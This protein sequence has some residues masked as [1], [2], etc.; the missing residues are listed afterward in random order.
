MANI[1]KDFIKLTRAA[2]NRYVLSEGGN[3]KLFFKEPFANGEYVF[4]IG[5]YSPELFPY[6]DPDCRLQLVCIK[7]GDKL[8]ILDEY[9]CGY[10]FTDEL[11][12]GVYRF[13]TTIAEMHQKVNEE[14]LPAYLATLDVSKEIM[15]EETLD[16]AKNAAVRALLSLEPTAKPPAI[17]I[18][19]LSQCDV[20]KILCGVEDLNRLTL[21]K[22]KEEEARWVRAEGYRRKVIEFMKSEDIIDG[23]QRKIA[24]AVRSVDAVCLTV[25]FT[26]G[27]K[28]AAGKIKADELLRQITYNGYFASFTFATQSEGKRILFYLGVTDD[29]GVRSSLTYQHISRIMYR[30]KTIYSA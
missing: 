15:D 14:I 22:L 1:S 13:R 8:Y 11:P 3:T 7:V 26:F 27:G 28:S 29:C 25:E 9:A 16:L 23:S 17:S 24:D 4:M 10:T 6:F 21:R 19:F 20:A 30:G 12:E 5:S 18:G 2:N